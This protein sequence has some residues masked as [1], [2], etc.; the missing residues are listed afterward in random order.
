MPFRERISAG[1]LASAAAVWLFSAPA[2]AAQPRALAPEKRQDVRAAISAEMARLKIPGLS[3]AIATDLRKVWAEGFG[4]ADVENAVPATA[5]TVYRLGSISKPITAV[6]AMQLAERG[7]LSLDAP[8]QTYVPTFPQKPWPITARELLGHLSGIRHYKGLGEILST[9]HYTDL[10]AP[11][12]VFEDDPLLFEPGTRYS[13]ST[14]GYS[15]LGAAVENASGMKF[16]DCL[17]ENVFVPAHME[18]IRQDDVY[19]IVA[20]RARGYRRTVAGDLRNCA[21]ADSSNKI[22]GGG[23]VSTTEDLVRFGAALERGELLEPRGVE[24]MF[25]SQKTRDGKLTQYGLGWKLFE[26]GGKKWAGHGGAQ[27]GFSTMLLVLPGES[28]AVVLMA[29]LEGLDLV[30]LAFRLAGIA[31]R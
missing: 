22:P 20:H 16:L 26:S 31:L 18:Q 13:Y 21:L 1:W 14:Y 12:K 8:I 29:N 10:L 15:L 25:T 7:K 2:G 3:A 19:E 23:L 27:P 24:E 17:R 28:V 9:Q 6:A 11:L 5:A 30:P 4:M